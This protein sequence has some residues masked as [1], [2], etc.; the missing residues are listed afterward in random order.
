[1]EYAN[2]LGMSK[3]VFFMDHQYPETNDGMSHS[4]TNIFEAKYCVEL[5]KYMLRQ[6]PWCSLRDIALK[7]S[8]Y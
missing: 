5:T 4:H 2:V 3:N 1:M 8:S 6:V 7:I